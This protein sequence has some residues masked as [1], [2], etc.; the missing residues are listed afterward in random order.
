M[1]AI[2]VKWRDV[3]A[4]LGLSVNQMDGIQQQSFLDPEQ[5][6]YRVFDHWIINNGEFTDYPITWRGLHELLR[7]IDNNALAE[8][9]K[10][11]LQTVGIDISEEV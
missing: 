6:C 8:R 10:A 11:A 4:L 5:C 2:G 9:M 1:E 3:A 7:D